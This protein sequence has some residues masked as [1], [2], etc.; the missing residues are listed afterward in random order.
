MS[1]IK[2]DESH[3]FS[4][5]HNRVKLLLRREYFPHEIIKANGGDIAKEWREWQKYVPSIETVMNAV[6]SGEISLHSRN[7]GKLTYSLLCEELGIDLPF[8][9][10][11]KNAKWRFCPYTGKQLPTPAHP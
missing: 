6:K 4:K 10:T 7:V 5:A 8:Q 3:W 1:T 9:R 11:V 2:V